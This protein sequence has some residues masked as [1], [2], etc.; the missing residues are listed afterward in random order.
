MSE[1]ERYTKTYTIF[2]HHNFLANNT[3][4]LLNDSAESPANGVAES[5]LFVGAMFDYDDGT[6]VITMQEQ[7]PDTMVWT[8]V[9]DEDTFPPGGITL[10]GNALVRMGYVGK[11][12]QTRLKVVST[13]I[14]GN[15]SHM[16]LNRVHSHLDN[17]PVDHQ[18]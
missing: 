8:D 1:V 2:Q 16:N 12:L 7:D 4:H 10:T 9:S 11:R 6:F 17:V 15:G 13:G 5:I 14:S 18:P 3:V